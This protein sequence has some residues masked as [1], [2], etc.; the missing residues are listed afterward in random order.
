M[1]LEGCRRCCFNFIRSPEGCF[2][3]LGGAKEVQVRKGCIVSVW[4]GEHG[5]GQV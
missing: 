5:E 4:W 2:G 1:G 3:K